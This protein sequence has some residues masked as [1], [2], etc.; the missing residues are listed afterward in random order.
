MSERIRLQ[1][2][3]N[4]RDLS[5]M[6]AAEGRRIQP[7]KLYRSG[8]FFGATDA[9]LAFIRENVSLIVDFRSA[10]EVQEKPDPELPGVEY[11]HLPAVDSLAA[12]VSRD[13]ESDEE[14]FDMVAQ[15]PEKARN[16]MIRNYA[17]FVANAFTVSQYRRFLQLLLQPRE[18]AILWHCT[19]GKDR[20]GFAALLIQTLLGVSEADIRKDYLATNTYLAEEILFLK[21]MLGPQLGGLNAQTEQALDWLFGAREDYLNAIFRQAETQYNSFDN[22]LTTALGMDEAARERLKALYLE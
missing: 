3:N 22:F 18:K 13:A 8:H 1:G 21:Q 17:S 11:L 5:G 19:A 9:D 14:A 2:M 20:T 4:T 12:G 10:K 7:G 16:Y 6:T 15:E